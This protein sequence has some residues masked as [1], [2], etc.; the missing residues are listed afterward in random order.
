MLYRVVCTANYPLPNVMTFIEQFVTLSNGR[1][2][3]GQLEEYFPFTLLRSNYI[4]LTLQQTT[5]A[6]RS[7]A[8]QADEKDAK[9][10]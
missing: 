4:R 8:V 1:L 5:A 6:N 3:L 7:G 10:Q 2:S 9:A